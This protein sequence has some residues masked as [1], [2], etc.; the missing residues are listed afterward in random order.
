MR[1]RKKVSRR[2]IVLGAIAVIVVAA[3][4]GWDFMQS[5]R[6]GGERMVDGIVVPTFSAMA[7]AG[8]TA[9]D[10]NCAQCH[11]RL[12]TGTD[13]GPAF[14]HRVYRPGHHGD[15]AFVRAVARGVRAHHWKFGNMPAQPQVAR[16]DV[17]AIIRYVREL[18]TANGIF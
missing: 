1:R 15:P 18:Q 8:E 11:G 6:S 3:A 10:A 2:T 17:D 14:L 7:A 16:D 12:G 9:Y 13:T 5:R 4:A